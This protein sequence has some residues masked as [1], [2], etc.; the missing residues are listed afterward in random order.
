M[1]SR[2]VR[3]CSS[4]RPARNGRRVRHGRLS[5]RRRSDDL[6]Q[7][8]QG[9]IR[10]LSGLIGKL[11]PKSGTKAVRGWFITRDEP[12]ADQRRVADRHRD[13]IN[14]LSFS[15]FQSKLVDSHTYLRCRNEY[16]F[17]SVRDPGTDDRHA[18]VDYIPL[19]L[20]DTKTGDVISRIA[21]SDSLADGSVIVLLG[22]YG[23]G[24]S[25][26]LRETYHDLRKAHLQGQCSY[27]SS[28]SEPARPLWS[29][30]FPSPSW[31]ARPS[32]GSGSWAIRSSAGR[33][34]CRAPV[35]RGPTTGLSSW[36]PACARRWRG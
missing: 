12:T 15:Q 13:S 29:R 28:L 5:P 19:D 1:A 33:T 10:K 16:A 36:P 20:T 27:V 17:G 6:P 31:R 25:M 21:L 2:P 3:R 18:T 35:R 24:K 11:R 22:D 32:T 4:C 9:D 23:A 30:R 26:S 14:T 34:C 8:R 7:A